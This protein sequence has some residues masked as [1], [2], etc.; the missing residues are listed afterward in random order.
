LA[1]LPIQCIEFGRGLLSGP[2]STAAERRVL[3]QEFLQSIGVAPKP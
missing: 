2:W 3:V 1:A